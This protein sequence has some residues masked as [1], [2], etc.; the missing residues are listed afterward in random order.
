MPPA[1]QPRSLLSLSMECVRGL[2]CAFCR[3]EHGARHSQRMKEEVM[4]D[5]T[6]PLLEQLIAELT[7]VLIN[8]SKDTNAFFTA[9][10]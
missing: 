2:V 4:A 10:K 6:A 9:F 3:S 8:R 1:R 7:D 5:L